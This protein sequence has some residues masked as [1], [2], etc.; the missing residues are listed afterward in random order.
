MCS[1]VFLL[2]LFLLLLRE[3]VIMV[4]RLHSL[5]VH[6]QGQYRTSK[7]TEMA[8]YNVAGKMRT[9]SNENEEISAE[10]LGTAF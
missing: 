4:K 9:C 2:M 10:P 5:S 1:I 6:S 7:T 3:V 8:P